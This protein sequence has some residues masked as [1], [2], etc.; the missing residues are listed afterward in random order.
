MLHQLLI[1]ITIVLNISLKG[2]AFTWIIII[3]HEIE[4]V[5][6]GEPKRNT[7]TEYKF[8]DSKYFGIKQLQS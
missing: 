7:C 6:I 8:P 4:F 1:F 3:R 5:A 2:F